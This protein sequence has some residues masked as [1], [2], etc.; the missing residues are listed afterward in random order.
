[1][2]SKGVSVVHPPFTTYHALLI[3]MAWIKRYWRVFGLL[4]LFSWVVVIMGLWIYANLHGYTYFSGGEPLWYVKWFEWFAGA[5]G[6][7]TAVD[8]LWAELRGSLT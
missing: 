8:Y 6:I 2:I 4:S 3:F 7:V 5:V 1:M